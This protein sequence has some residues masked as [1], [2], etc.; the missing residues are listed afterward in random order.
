MS[1]TVG[2]QEL[3]NHGLTNNAE[4]I[5]RKINTYLTLTKPQAWQSISKEILSPSLPFSLHKFLFS[6]C[7]PDW[8]DHPELAPVFIPTE[9]FITR[10]NLYHLMHKLKLNNVDDFYAWSCNQ[11][12][13]FW[14]L[15]I[16]TLKIKLQK[17]AYQL[18]D[19]SLGVTKPMWL[20][21]AELNIIESCFQAPAEKIALIYQDNQQQLQTMTYAELN[22]LSNRVANSLTKLNFKKNDAIAI[23]MPMT[24]EA[25]IIYLGI[26][27]MGGIVV[28]V[29]DSFSPEEIKIRLEIGNAKTVFT[30]DYSYRDQKK[31][32]LYEKIL[33]THANQII[34]ITTENIVLRKEDM[35]WQDF[36][37]NN[38]NFSALPG[39]AMDT[40]HILFSSGTTGTPKAIPWNQATAIKAASDAYLH[41]N[42]QNQDIICWP[43][44]LGWMMGPWLIFAALI[45]QATIAIYADN[46]GTTKFGQF[47]QEAK[48]TILGVVP[49]LVATWRQNLSMQD[50]DW[51]H[52]KTFSSTGECSNV[53]DMLYLTSVAGYKPIIE[54]CGGTEIGG[55]YI[56][57]TVIENNYLSIF[58]RPAFGNQF[59]LLNENGQPDDLGEVALIPPALGLSTHLLNADHDNIYYAGM[60]SYQQKILRRHGDLIQ[61]FSNQLYRNLGRIDDTMKLGGIKISSAEIE[62]ALVGIEGITETAAIGFTPNN[63]GPT[64][65]IIFAA[66]QLENNHKD[67]ILKI[68]QDKIK[69]RLNPLF[70]IHELVF[71]KELPKTASHKIMR[72]VLREIYQKNAKIV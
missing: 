21:G 53:E 6:L 3:L 49:T 35:T 50:L 46:P 18:C 72:R 9:E 19:L 14:Q 67:L 10:T 56:S 31:I 45:N 40:C 69:L 37:S 58:T 43:T 59:I 65:L 33:A 20:P 51:S 36:L 28:S 23:A 66:T 22:S 55:A 41:Q 25:I 52:I 61:R 68:M 26:I 30:Q 4:A 57:S 38:N 24:K 13:D 62:R 44:N 32:P 5:A 29:A 17:P 63:N 60:P 15:M 47:I 70:K 54:Y 16:T 8:Q 2:T 7:Y 12:E 64:Q 34:V 39:S 1:R 11:S 71:I 27:K 48:V 42:I